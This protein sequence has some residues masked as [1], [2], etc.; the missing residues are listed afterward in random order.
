[1]PR[2]RRN[3]L[4]V[5]ASLVLLSLV[6]VPLVLAYRGV[7]NAVN[8]VITRKRSCEQNSRSLL[9]ANCNPTPEQ[10]AR[11]ASIPVPANAAD[12]VSTFSS[13]QDSF[14]EANFTVPKE[15]LSDYTSLA[16][17][18]DVALDAPGQ[19]VGPSADGLYRTLTLTTEGDRI[20][21][22]IEAFTT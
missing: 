4:I 11:F 20:R 3:T 16:D 10:V 13:F 19:Q 6:I 22:K 14:L 1:M 18:P 15:S 8:P 5:I 12:F 21:V 7:S 2:R 9:G 17:F